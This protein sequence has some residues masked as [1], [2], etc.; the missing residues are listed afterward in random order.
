MEIK[1]VADLFGRDLGDFVVKEMFEVLKF[2]GDGKALTSLGFL[3]N[4]EIAEGF[5]NCQ[6]CPQ[7]MTIV[8]RSI[9]TD[10]KI[11]FI[12]KVDAVHLLNEGRAKQAIID[13][14]LAKLSPVGRK[15]IADV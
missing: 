3:E 6:R 5:A 1:R 8:S 2:E 4:K 13:Y 14:E 9:L 11:G 15:L 10:G 12:L 7:H